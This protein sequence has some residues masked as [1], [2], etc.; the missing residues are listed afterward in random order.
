M[1]PPIELQALDTPGTAASKVNLKSNSIII[2]LGNFDAALQPKVRSILSR[3]VAPL[4]LD[5][6]A[7]IVDN[8]ATSGSAAA[9]GLAARD[10]ETPPA[11]LAI[12]ANNA[13]D[14]DPDH[15]LILRLPAG[16]PDTIKSTFQIAGQLAKGPAR[17]LAPEGDTGTRPHGRIGRV[18]R[19]ISWCI[20]SLSPKPA[21]PPVDATKEP[22]VKQPDVEDK[23]VLAVLFGGS[24][25]DHLIEVKFVLRQGAAQEVM[26][27]VAHDDG[28]EFE[29]GIGN[30]GREA[31]RWIILISH[32][33]LL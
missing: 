17:N 9:M 14:F 22:E 5:S 18:R 21:A 13:K 10:Q 32:E 16:W 19:F 20:E 15:P 27:V 33:V 3:A 2:L 23:S 28:F 6:G 12:V 8:G 7:L 30:M 24:D 4:A 1:N 29:I 11:L 26:I 31:E 25:D